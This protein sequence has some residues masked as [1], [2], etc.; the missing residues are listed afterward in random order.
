[1]DQKHWYLEWYDRTVR[2]AQRTL[3]PVRTVA[4]T[5]STPYLTT[6]D[7]QVAV[8]TAASL[9]AR[10][11][12]AVVLSFP[13]VTLLPELP[14]A[15]RSLHAVALAEMKAANPHAGYAIRSTEEGDFHFHL[16]PDGA[17]FVV[18]GAGWNAYVGPA[19]SPLFAV[20]ETNGM[21]AALA[22]ILASAHLFRDPFAPFAVPFV[23][24]TF[25]W[26][27][28]AATR[29]PAFRRDRS[30]GHIFVAGLGSVGSSALYFLSLV[31]RNFSA[32]LVD[33]DKVTIANITRSPIFSAEDARLEV[34]KVASVG[35]FL[36]NAGVT[37]VRADP[38]A[39][40]ESR[41][42]T[43]RQAGT[44]DL[45]IAAANERNVRYH[46]E[47]AYPPIQVYAT[48][49]NNWQTTL[50]KHVPGDDTCSLCL[51]PPDP[52][53]APMACGTDG[54]ARQPIQ[55]GEQVDA[56]LPFLSF[57]AGL[58]TA[59]EIVKLAIPELPVIRNRVSLCLRD[60]PTMLQAPIAHR[61]GCT[62]EA[63]S[64]TVHFAMTDGSLFAKRSLFGIGAQP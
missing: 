50:I 7:G 60:R 6:F 40:D 52:T 31:T 10:M 23:C 12:P 57:A 64:R 21:G 51:F 32:T 42:W 19:P 44:P 24:N 34:A 28:V 36:R 30:L 59:S 56:A 48:T 11:T 46:I 29:M 53:S 5:A 35:T 17:D 15:G 25:D 39:L 45:V 62:C 55:A 3:D 63:R 33:M 8:L 41:F 2:Y 14:W 47:M 1:M 38:V 18:H 37:N 61:S 27:E 26:Q 16:G 20:D 22:V 54:A 58:M 49:G 4:I 43:D 9:L 13:D